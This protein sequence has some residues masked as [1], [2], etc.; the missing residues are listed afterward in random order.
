MLL[1]LGVLIGF[2][3]GFFGIGGGT[4]LIPILMYLGFTI[5][6]AIGISIMQMVFSSIFGSYV[7][8]KNGMLKLGDGVFLGLGGSTGAL[9]SGYI[10]K[11][12]DD[13]MLL[14]IFALALFFSIYK[15]F[16]ANPEHEGKPKESKFLLFLV[17]AFVGM[18][19]MSIGI[20]G[21]LLLTTKLVGLL[22]FCFSLYSHLF[23]VLLV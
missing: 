17:G 20:G 4:V 11:V 19:A 12:L 6:E 2:I 10:V 7:N 5:K 13:W 23:R 16:K 22:R 3:S 15:F 1:L 9:L 8:Y 14:S 18:I 21:D